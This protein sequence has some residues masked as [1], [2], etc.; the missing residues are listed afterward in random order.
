VV[1]AFHSRFSLSFIWERAPLWFPRFIHASVCRSFGRGPLCGSRVSFTLLSVIH[2][3]EG[4]SVVPAFHSRFCL[5]FARGFFLPCSHSFCSFTVFVVLLSSL[6]HHLYER[7]LCPGLMLR[8]GRCGQG[9]HRGCGDPQADLRDQE[10]LPGGGSISVDPRGGAGGR[11]VR[12]G[13]GARS[14]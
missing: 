6:T 12:R 14:V 5:S 11:Q 8:C 2:L 10:R 3:G 13:G 1:P 9:P 4:P 7:V